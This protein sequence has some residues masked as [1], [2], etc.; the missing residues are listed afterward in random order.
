MSNINGVGQT[1][2]INRLQAPTVAKKPV[3][4]EAAQRGADRV[5]L[6]NVDPALLAKLKNNDIRADKVAD[7]RAQIEKGTYE[8]DEKLNGAIDKLLD[9][10][11]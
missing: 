7:I 8:N 11:V 5:E 3:A 2:N 1:G 6:G 10:M 4:T 9:D